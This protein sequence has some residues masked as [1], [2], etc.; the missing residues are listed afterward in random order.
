MS[1]ASQ[2]LAHCRA[3]Y[4]DMGFGVTVTF[5]GGVSVRRAAGNEWVDSL[6]TLS[7]ALVTTYY[8]LQVSDYFCAGLC[9]LSCGRVFLCRDLFLWVPVSELVS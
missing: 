8:P 9:V 7:D 1:F 3:S 6:L 5:D 2:V 4:P